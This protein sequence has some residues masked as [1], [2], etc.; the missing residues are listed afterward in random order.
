ERIFIGVGI[1]A[2]VFTIAGARFRSF[3]R[4][5]LELTH[6]QQVAFSLWCGAIVTTLLLLLCWLSAR[7]WKHVMQQSSD[8]E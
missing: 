7:T 6:Y 1:A 5:D 3:Q 8:G 2:C 4:N